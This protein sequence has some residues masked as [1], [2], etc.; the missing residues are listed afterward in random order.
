MKSKRQQ[1]MSDPGAIHFSRRA[2]ARLEQGGWRFSAA[3]HSGLAGAVDDLAAKGCKTAL[4]LFDQ[5]ALL[6]SVGPRRVITAMGRQTMEQNLM[7][8]IDG[9]F[10]VSV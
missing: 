1:V 9:V 6:V 3:M 7:T 8:D 10:F 2:S 5:L 4:V